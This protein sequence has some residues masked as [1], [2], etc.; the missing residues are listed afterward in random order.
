MNPEDFNPTWQHVEELFGILKDGA[1]KFIEAG[2]CDG[3]AP[4]LGVLVYDPF[5]GKEETRMNLMD[6]GFN[7]SLEKKKAMKI[8]AANTFA[9]HKLP[10]A[11]GLV[12]EAWTAQMKGKDAMEEYYKKHL[13][14][15]DDPER[16]EVVQVAAM[17]FPVKDSKAE[18]CLGMADH[19]KV[20]RD[21]KEIMS[22]DGDWLLPH[23]DKAEYQCNL[24]AQFYQALIDFGMKRED[25]KAYMAQEMTL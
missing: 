22:W 7:G 14:I 5:T 8:A 24:L 9:A 16:V 20:K 2:D 4:M 21:S 10:L 17:G 1:S 6:V 13:M 15:A 25:Y 23:D 3:L 18:K 12:S 11:V 19:R